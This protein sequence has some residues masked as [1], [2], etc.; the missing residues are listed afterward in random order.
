MPPIGGCSL[1]A[2]V[3]SIMG[4]VMMAVALGAL[5]IGRLKSISVAVEPSAEIKASDPEL[6]TISAG[7]QK[8]IVMPMA[9]QEK[10]A[11]SEE[12]ELVSEV[13]D[14]YGH[15]AHQVEVECGEHVAENCPDAENNLTVAKKLAIMGDYEGAAELAELVVESSTSSPSQRARASSLV[16]RSRPR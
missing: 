13:P 1:N 16:A 4:A 2:E 6:P 11:V 8:R 9:P 5:W 14:D 12:T 7:S 10:K 3:M 15:D